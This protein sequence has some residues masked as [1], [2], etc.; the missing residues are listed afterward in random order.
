MEALHVER[1]SGSLD[2]ALVAAVDLGLGPG[3]HL[4]APVQ[5]GGSCHAA[6]GPRHL[7]LGP[8]NGAAEALVVAQEPG[9]WWPEATLLLQYGVHQ[10]SRIAALPPRG[11]R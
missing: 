6:P 10:R 2:D 4:E 1:T 9:S 5:R 3:E 11:R 7:E 8:L